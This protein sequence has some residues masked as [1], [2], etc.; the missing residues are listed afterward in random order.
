M[1]RRN[2]KVELIKRVPLF[3]G[4]SKG[5]LEQIAHIADEI[6]LPE[7]KELTRQGERGREFLVLLEGNADVTQDGQSINQLGSGDFFGAGGSAPTWKEPLICGCASHC[8]L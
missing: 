4:C 7:G 8:Q 1:L 6:D 3:A 2:E 5:E